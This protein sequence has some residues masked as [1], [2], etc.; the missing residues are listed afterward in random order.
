LLSFMTTVSIMT[1]DR[2]LATANPR[3]K[4]KKPMNFIQARSCLRQ[5]KCQVYDDHVSVVEPDRK[6]NEVLKALR[7][8]YC[9]S[10]TR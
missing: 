8:E 1:I 10:I 6:S 3:A 4:N 9:R 5:M 7:I 2:L